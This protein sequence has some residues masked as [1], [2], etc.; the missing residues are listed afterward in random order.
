MKETHGQQISE[1]V[2]HNQKL[3]NQQHAVMS[4][5]PQSLLVNTTLLNDA[6]KA[7]EKISVEEKIKFNKE[8]KAIEFGRTVEIENIKQQYEF[9]LNK[10]QKEAEKV[11]TSPSE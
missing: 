5:I 4:S 1:L 6:R 11:R 7:N 10:K 9:W 3:L 2:S 8:L